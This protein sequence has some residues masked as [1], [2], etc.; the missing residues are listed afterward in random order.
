MI[1]TPYTLLLDAD[2]Q[3]DRGVV[4]ALR[5]KDARTRRGVHFADGHALHIIRLGKTADARVC[6]LFQNYIRFAGE[7]AATRL[8][9]PQA[10]VCSWRPALEQIGGFESIKS[11]VIDDCA[12]AGRAKSQGFRIWLGLTHSVKSVRR[13]Q[14]L[15]EIWDMVARTA[16]DQ[17]RYSVGAA[18]SMHSSNGASVS[19]AGRDGGFW[20]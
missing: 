7:L 20:G 11:A 4:R 14:R 10:D 12:L 19:S 6:A 2:I 3:L 13:Y 16:F 1:A 17:L 5:R 8:Q 18:D 9:R 15:K